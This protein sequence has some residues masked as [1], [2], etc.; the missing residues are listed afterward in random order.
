MQVYICRGGAAQKID[1]MDYVDHDRRANLSKVYLNVLH[2]REI[3][4]LPY[5]R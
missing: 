1:T 5:L 2:A 4:E 3:D